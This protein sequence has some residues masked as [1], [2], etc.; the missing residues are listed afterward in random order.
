MDALDR[1]PIRMASGGSPMQASARAAMRSVPPGPGSSG[2][3]RVELVAGAGADSGVAAF[4]AGLVRT[5][6]LQLKAA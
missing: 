6:K 5:G 2:V 3:V 1:R 4:I